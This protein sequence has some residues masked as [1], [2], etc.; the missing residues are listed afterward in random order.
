MVRL[1]LQQPI[2][3]LLIGFLV[4]LC[5]GFY[6][7]HGRKNLLKSAFQNF[8]TSHLQ[9]F[10]GVFAGLPCFRHELY[11]KPQSG[12]IFSKFSTCSLPGLVIIKGD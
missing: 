6:F 10:S 5:L 1:M 9:P 8:L 3:H 2:I 12:K 7:F 11:R 4:L